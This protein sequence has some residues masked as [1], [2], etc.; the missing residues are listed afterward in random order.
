MKEQALGALTAVVAHVRAHY[1][2][3]YEVLDEAL[4]AT[5]TRSVS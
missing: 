1:A 4:R 2:E 5:V 3:A